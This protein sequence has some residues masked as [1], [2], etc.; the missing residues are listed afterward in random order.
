VSSLLSRGADPNYRK[1]GFGFWDMVRIF[2]LSYQKSFFSDFNSRRHCMLPVKSHLSVVIELIKNGSQIDV[3]V[4]YEKFE[5]T[6]IL[7][8][9]I[10]GF[11]G[12]YLFFF[13]IPIDSK[14]IRFFLF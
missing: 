1:T 11:F 8:S 3:Q 2:F 10:L 14:L 9:F 7:I 4:N 12:L 5:T 13:Q 6:K